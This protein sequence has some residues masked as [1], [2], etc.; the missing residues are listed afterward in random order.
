MNAVRKPAKIE[1][2]YDHAV[3][4]D[5][6][7]ALTGGYPETREEYFEVL[8]RDS[9]LVGLFKLYRLRGDAGKAGQYL[10][11]IEDAQL[12]AQFMVRPCCVGHS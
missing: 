11:Q 5:E 6:I 1:T 9:A 7:L 10:N 2:I 8:S 4:Q 12:K 3:T